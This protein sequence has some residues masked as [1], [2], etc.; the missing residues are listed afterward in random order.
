LGRIAQQR[1]EVSPTRVSHGP[2]HVAT[3]LPSAAVASIPEISDIPDVGHPFVASGRKHALPPGWVER[4][5]V[6]MGS[7]TSYRAPVENDRFVLT[8]DQ[9]AD[10]RTRVVVRA[11]TDP[12]QLS[13]G[14]IKPLLS[15]FPKGD[16]RTKAARTPLDLDGARRARAVSRMVPTGQHPPDSG[17]LG[18]G[19]RETRRGPEAPGPWSARGARGRA[20]AGGGPPRPPAPPV[21]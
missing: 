9:R 21:A 5:L 18:R 6:V 7:A 20:S 15:R 11:P 10:Y 17:V 2:H 19:G 3:A 14:D 16:W 4:E 1:H 12:A 13:V 8:E